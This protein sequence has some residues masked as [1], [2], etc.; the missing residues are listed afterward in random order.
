MVLTLAGHGIEHVCHP[1]DRALQ[2]QLSILL[3]AGAESEVK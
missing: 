3:F 1:A 2:P